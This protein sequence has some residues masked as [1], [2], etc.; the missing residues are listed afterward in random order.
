[1]CARVC[2]SVSVCTQ[3]TNILMTVA[4]IRQ[5]SPGSQQRTVKMTVITTLVTKA[6]VL[7]EVGGGFCSPCECLLCGHNGLLRLC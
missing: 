5:R 2:V 3:L 1:M 6:Y 7:G 4:G